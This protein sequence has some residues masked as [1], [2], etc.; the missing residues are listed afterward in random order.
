[1][2]ISS[3]EM[4]VTINNFNGLS[5]E[6]DIGILDHVDQRSRYP[7]GKR[8]AEI[9]CQCYKQEYNTDI[10]I[11]RP[12]HLFGHIF[13]KQQISNCH[14]SIYTKCFKTKKIWSLKMTDHKYIRCAM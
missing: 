11:A 9:L 5:K 8:A 2:F 12:C 10:V 14:M 1:M 6:S 3:G 13:L 7:A 4:Y